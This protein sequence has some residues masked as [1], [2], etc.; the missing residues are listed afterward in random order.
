MFC[1]FRGLEFEASVNNTVRTSKQN[2]PTQR[3]TTQHFNYTS[4]KNNR[5]AVSRKPTIGRPKE[6]LNKKYFFSLPTHSLSGASIPTNNTYPRNRHLSPIAVINDAGTC[7]RAVQLSVNAV[8]NSHPVHVS[9]GHGQ[10][11][12]QP[13]ADN[14]DN[15][16]KKSNADEDESTDIS[17]E[18][19]DANMNPGRSNNL[20]DHPHFPKTINSYN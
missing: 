11:L 4:R 9:D 13:H 17:N 10:E 7:S 15:N 20:D 1:D 6:A 16:S 3:N 8:I 12:R 18:D 19:A 5:S 14:V 2:I